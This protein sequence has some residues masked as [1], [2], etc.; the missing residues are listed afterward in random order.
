[1]E[2]GNKTLNT[3][4]DEPDARIYPSLYLSDGDANAVP[5]PVPGD[6]RRF[7]GTVR[8]SSVEN[9]KGGDRSVR[10]EVIEMTVEGK[11]QPTAADRAYPTMVK[12]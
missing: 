6:E 11:E 12:G 8:I 5:D 2:L 3:M 1:M 4:L 10:L 7:T 9:S